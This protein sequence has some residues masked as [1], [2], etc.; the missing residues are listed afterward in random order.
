MPQFVTII[1]IVFAC[2]LMLSL[3]FFIMRRSILSMQNL[4][5][6]LTAVQAVHSVSTPRTGGVAVVLAFVLGLALWLDGSGNTL[7]H[8]KFIFTLAPVFFIGILEDLGYFISPRLRILS[9]A[10]SGLLF[11]YLFNQWIPRSDLP[12]LDEILFWSPFAI[13]LSIFVAVAISHAF[14]LIDGLNGL[15]AFI[16]IAAALALAVMADGVGLSGHR[17]MLL[18]LAAAIAGFLLLNFPFGWLFLGD[19]GAYTIGHILVWISISIIWSSEQITPWAI[20]L[21][22]FWPIG[23]T[24]LAIT[25]RLSKGRPVSQ[26]DRLHFHQLVLRACEILILGRKRRR[27][28]N[29]LATIL[30]L[31][32]AVAPMFAGVFFSTDRNQALLAILFFG[33]VFVLSYKVGL[34][35]ARKRNKW[36]IF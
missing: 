15:S 22:F 7:S 23:D 8:S 36:R 14:N 4:R 17:N 9:S 27:F 1:F 18:V 5:N 13:A 25:R 11:V 10:A 6:D 33:L 2:S 28:A 16:G 34:A 30:V 21:I 24:I 20:F 3:V 35:I 31:P 19:A 12:I 29:P 32:L 26:P